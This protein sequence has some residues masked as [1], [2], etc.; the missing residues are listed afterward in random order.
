MS[1]GEVLTVFL[2]AAFFSVNGSTTL[3]LLEQDLVKRLHVLSPPDFAT[4]VA[5]GATS[6]GPFG[7]GCI[8]VG[9]LADGWRGAFVATFTSWLPALLSLPLRAAYRHLEG[10]PW[11]GGVTWGVAAAGTGLLAAMVI[12]LASSTVTGWPEA[13]LAVGVLLLLSRRLPIPLV[14]MLAAAA[15][16]L[17][18]R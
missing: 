6:P 10:R 13:A 16:A 18:L 8:A 12:S 14:L 9:F 1:W 3:A 5:I 11:I 17:F 2:R 4:G 15:G 7:Y